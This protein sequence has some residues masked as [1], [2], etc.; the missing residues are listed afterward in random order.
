VTRFTA[1]IVAP[2]VVV[3]LLGAAPAPEPLSRADVAKLAKPATALVDGRPA[4]QGSSFCIHSSG[5]FLTNEHVVRTLGPEGKVTLVLDSGLSSQKIVKAKLIRSDKELDLA[6]LQAEGVKD[7]PALKLGSDDGLTELQ[8][9]IAFGFP[10]GTALAK[11]GEYPA[12]TINVVNVSS[13][14]T[15]AKRE[16]SRIQLDSNLN[17]G[18]SGGP[19]V[20]RYGKVMGVVV[21]GIRGAGINH[22]IPVRHV[23][24]FLDRPVLVFRPPVINRKSQHEMAEF[25]AVATVLGGEAADLELE[26]TLTQP[27]GEMRKFPMKREAGKYSVKAIPFPAVKSDPIVRIEIKYPDGLINAAVK[28]QTFKVGMETVKLSD[29]RALRPAVISD[30]ELPDGKRLKGRLGGIETLP[31]QLGGQSIDLRLAGMTELRVIPTTKVEGRLVCT[32]IARKGEKEVGRHEES[33]YLEGTQ[34]ATLEGLKE[35]KFIKPFQATAPTSYLKAVSSPGD[36][37]GQGKSYSFEG[38]DLRVRFTPQ[39]ITVDV[40]GWNIQ[41]APPRGGALAVGE[42]PNCKRF[43]FNDDSPGLSYIGHGRGSNQVGGKFV[44]WE[45]EIN[46]GQ[47][48][49]MAIDF[50]HRSE[51]TG[52]PLYG[53]LRFN[54]SLE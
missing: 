10:F 52:P 53:M 18:N 16:L 26:L 25:H 45:L 23:H 21:S 43:P 36:F 11:P 1:Q 17:P 20:D 47:V 19:V 38:K 33:V 35:G 29:I 49:K 31:I 8:E 4:G 3:L 2:F 46:G 41:F 48:T 14:R 27:T 39:A 7:L 22:A 32:I 50:I 40:E 34:R 37:I 12:I 51:I 5:L 24:K 9:L 42:Y 6:L 30:V 15:D 54:S 44:I 28:D 13:L